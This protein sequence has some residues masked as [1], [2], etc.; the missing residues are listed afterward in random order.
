VSFQTWINRYNDSKI[1][2]A[3]LSLFGIITLSFASILSA[4]NV[5]QLLQIFE[6]AFPGKSG[7]KITH[8][9]FH[10]QPALVASA[11]FWLIVGGLAYIFRKSFLIYIYLL[12]LIQMALT[13]YAW[14]AP[15]FVK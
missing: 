5:D 8:L 1:R 14:M 6:R 4:L 11:F 15:V 13:C 3:Q 9:F 2:H 10:F 7:P 12:V